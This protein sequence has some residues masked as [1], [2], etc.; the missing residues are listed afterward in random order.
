MELL[1]PPPS[2]PKLRAFCE[3]YIVDKNGKAA[4][5]RAGYSAKTAAQAAHRNIKI[6]ECAAYIRYLLS[7]VA[8]KVEITAERVLAEYAKIAFIDPR[9]F[10]D[11]DGNLV[12]IPQLNKDVAAAL[13]G[14]EVTEVTS[15]NGQLESTTKKIKLS[16]K[17]AALDSIARHLGMFDDKL[18]LDHKGTINM[19]ITGADAD[20]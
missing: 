11:E 18:S 20:L 3:E 8:E 14:M 13:T 7:K 19:T 10:Y 4:A 12:P 5:I 9:A 1:P 2:V 6:P 17:K 15:K 16:D